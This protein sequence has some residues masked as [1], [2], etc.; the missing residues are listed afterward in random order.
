MDTKGSINHFERVHALLS[1]SGANRWMSCT[2]SA[3]LEEQYGGPDKPS[4]YAA[5]GTIA[6]ELAELY[7]RHDILQ[8]CED[9]EFNEKLGALMDNEHFNEEMFDEVPKYVG[10]IQEQVN[11]AY[12]D[13]PDPAILL[14]QKVDLTDYIPE[15]FGSC[16]FIL[17]CDGHMEVVDL[18]YGKGIPVSATANKQLMLYALGAYHK[19]EMMYEINSVSLTIVQPRLDNISTWNITVNDLLNWAKTEVKP[20]AELA[21]KGEGD[22]VAGDWCRFCKVKNRCKQLAAKNLELAKHEFKEPELLTDEEIADILEKGP[23][24]VE[25][26]NS[27]QSYALTEATE[28]YKVWP[29][30]KLV[31]GRSMR[32]WLNEDDVEQRLLANNY[33]E[34]EIYNLKL[35]GI[36]DI[37]KVVGGKVAF[38]ALLSDLVIKPQGK[39]TLVPI[40][41]KRPALGTEDAVNDFKD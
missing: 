1:A 7:I 4:P 20:K 28:N 41:D 33:G 6:H 10:Y 35:K 34:D 11:A 15:A 24:F 38:E 12:V 37:Q 31:E 16:D 5:E 36:S 26:F 21:F 18:K 39:P 27:I 25:W 17:I 23:K 29:G 8:N 40:S 2:P 3:R 13:T 30:F 32:K 19:Y 9:E 14:E 22:L